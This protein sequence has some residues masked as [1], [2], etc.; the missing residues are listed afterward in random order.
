MI[1]GPL[2]VDSLLACGAMLEQL[3]LGEAD[4]IG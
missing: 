2:P 1:E 3:M 4:I